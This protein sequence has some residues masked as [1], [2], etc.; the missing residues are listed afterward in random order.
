MADPA[1]RGTGPASATR[2]R[3][4]SPGY[5]RRR[6]RG[7]P[8]SAAPA[9][10][11]PSKIRRFHRYQWVR[12]AVFPSRR[13]RTARRHTGPTDCDGN[14][15]A[16]RDDGIKPID[17]SEYLFSSVIFFKVERSTIH[18]DNI[19]GRRTV[20]MPALCPSSSQWPVDCR[21]PGTVKLLPAHRDQYVSTCDFIQNTV[22]VDEHSSFRTANSRKVELYSCIPDTSC[23]RSPVLFDRK[24][25]F[26]IRR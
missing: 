9:R 11:S 25:C 1:L 2:S 12:A 16:R 7:R 21:P 6:R 17:L 14:A 8:C 4:A 10:S 19:S 3:T 26:R 24:F 15:E 13:R 23:R 18:Y 5:R 20:G 22:G